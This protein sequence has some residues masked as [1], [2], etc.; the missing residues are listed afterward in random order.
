M[1]LNLRVLTMVFCIGFALVQPVPTYAAEPL[2]QAQQFQVE[3]IIEEYL[4]E[5]PALMLKVLQHV[6]RFQQGKEKKRARDNLLRLNENLYDDPNSVILGDPHAKVTIVEFFDYR[7]GYCKKNHPIFTSFRAQNRD[8]NVIFK[9]FPILGPESVFASRAAI[10]S[11]KQGKYWELHDT[12]MT[13]RAEL[14]EQ[15]VFALAKEVGL[16]LARLRRDIAAPEIDSIIRNNYHLAA[17]LGINGTPGFVI[18]DNI[19][20]GFLNRER[21]AIAVD[22]ART[23]CLTCLHQQ[24]D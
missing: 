15:H 10:A 7:C 8:I 20:P 12:L 24:R 23:D 11:R 16:D 22:E 13:T 18:G 9:E 14:T 3:R 6:R 19:I 4:L 21:L 5:N 1:I 17:A 2:S